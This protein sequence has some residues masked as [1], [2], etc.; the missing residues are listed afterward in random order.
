MKNVYILRIVNKLYDDTVMFYVKNLKR[1]FENRHL[2]V[3]STFSVKIPRRVVKLI[4]TN[5]F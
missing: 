5:N 3:R 4:K 2:T 1:N